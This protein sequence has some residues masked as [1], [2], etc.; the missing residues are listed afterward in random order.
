MKLM[1]KLM[2][3]RSPWVVHGLADSSVLGMAIRLARRLQIRFKD[4]H[5]LTKSPQSMEVW[6]S[7]EI[8]SII[9]LDKDIQ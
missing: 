2:Q 3:L 4:V 8:C 1:L 9:D 5:R 7:K 6:F